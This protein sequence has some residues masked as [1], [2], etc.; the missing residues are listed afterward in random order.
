[1]MI[2]TAPAQESDFAHYLERHQNRINDCLTQRLARLRNLNPPLGE[3]ME[4]SLM[5]KGKRLRPILA[6][7][8][9][10]AVGQI[11]EAV[12][13][14]ACALECIHTY[15]LIHDDLPAM[16]DDDLRRGL[17]TCH[18]AFDE[19]TAILAGDALLTLAFQWLAEI[20]PLPANIRIE[21]ITHL[22]KAAGCAGMVG[23]QM[24]DLSAVGKPLNL[25]QLEQLHRHKTGALIKASVVMGAMATQ[26]AGETQLQQLS[27][28]ADAVGLAFQIHDDVLDVESNTEA[29]GKSQGADARLNK[30]TYVSIAGLDTAK[31]LANQQVNNA[32]AA[33]DNFGPRAD[34]LRHVARYTIAREF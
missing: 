29:L 20:H 26:A 8:A 10:D 3:A 23:G 30:P 24:Q 14:V 34:N 31:E 1:M 18:K 27:D 33:L 2:D 22:S 16:D 21:L 13:T 12:D 7:A 4:Y 11:D 6:Y 15:S 32:L 19:A 9:A 5:A 25:P 28:Y 17:P